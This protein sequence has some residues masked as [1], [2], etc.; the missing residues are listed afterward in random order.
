MPPREISLMKF[1][2]VLVQMGAAVVS[3]YKLNM[4]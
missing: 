1:L 2:F 4:G 3:G